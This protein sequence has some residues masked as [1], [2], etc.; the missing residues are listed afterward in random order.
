MFGGD[1]GRSHH[2]ADSCSGS[3]SPF[4]DRFRGSEGTARCPLPHVDQSAPSRAWP[5]SRLP[6]TDL[7]RDYRFPDLGLLRCAKESADLFQS[8]LS[9][10]SAIPCPS[11]LPSHK[12]ARSV[13]FLKGETLSSLRECLEEPRIDAQ[14]HVLEG[15]A[16]EVIRQAAAMEM[17][18]W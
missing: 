11:H 4:S 5:F 1:G 9:F 15:P 8:R 7:W 10:V 12:D 14:V 16:G 6:P 3:A 2:D 18:I 17:R 13:H